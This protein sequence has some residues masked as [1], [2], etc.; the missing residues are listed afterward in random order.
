MS[1]AQLRVLAVTN[2]WPVGGSFRGIFVQEQVHA[3]RKLGVHVDVEVMAQQRGKADYLLG[4]HR[5]RRR[6]R[7]G[8]TDGTDGAYDIA[9]FHYGLTAL[10]ARLAGPIPTVLSIYGSDIN[11]PWQRRITRLGI[12]H[13]DARIYVSEN[14]RKAANDSAG[15]IIPHGVDL[16]LFQPTGQVTQRA[17]GSQG[18][19][20]VLFGAHP[21]NPV[22]GYDV[23]TAVLDELRR[24]GLNVRELLLPGQPRNEV[25]RKFEAADI[26][27]FTSQQGTE[28]SPGV[29]KEA[30][31]MGLPVVSVDVGDVRQTLADVKPSAVVDFGDRLVERLAD[32][33]QEI[34]LQNT[35]SDGRQHADRFDWKHSARRVLAVY[36]EVLPPVRSR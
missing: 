12:E 26:L 29:L 2:V 18:A 7:G 10:A 6:L 13:A 33:A 28:G 19:H 31:A 15:H 17:Q 20:F 23:F 27:L 24:R 22:K 5:V 25:P 11:V 8:G 35:R 34:L 14:L 30:V 4:A 1:E 9:H 32:R 3:L 36:E 21:A 16:S